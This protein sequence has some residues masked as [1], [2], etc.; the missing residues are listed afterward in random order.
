ML[1]VS[2]FSG[3]KPEEFDEKS[4]EK[5]DNPSIP[6]D[7]KATISKDYWGTWIRMDTGDEYYIDN[8]AVYKLTGSTKTKVQ[9]GVS[10]FQ[11]ESPE[12]IKS[13]N[14]AYFRKGGASRSFTLGLSG[15][16]SSVARAAGIG[17]QTIA[18]R[19]KNKD[20]SS[21]VQTVSATTSGDEGKLSFTEAVPDDTQTVEV[22]VDSSTVAT[23]EVT[24]QYDGENV[25]TI[26]IV[27]KNKY[28]LKTTYT[29]NS[30]LEDYMYGNNYAEY[31]ITLK[32]ENTVLKS[33]ICLFIRLPVMIPIL[34]LKELKKKVTSE[35]FWLET[36]KNSREKFLTENWNLNIRML[37]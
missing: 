10:N 11:L 16:S 22:T 8:N 34:S 29:I 37:F 32:I 20:N 26:P 3:C 27:E 21:D 6:G 4:E 25:G 7:P 14:I 2:M 1:A 30:K 12:T 28:A 31:D 33:V 24:P 23:V 15:F 17:N 9:Y 13:G 35:H 5:N 36:I 18:G 19:R